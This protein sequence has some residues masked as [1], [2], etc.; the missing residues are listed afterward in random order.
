M[1]K[2]DPKMGKIE[3]LPGRLG[4]PQRTTLRMGKSVN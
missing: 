2:K 1:W 3:D 4:F